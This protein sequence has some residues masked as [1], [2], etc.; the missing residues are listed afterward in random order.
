MI[1]GDNRAAVV[2]NIAQ[3]V[4]RGDLNTKVELNDPTLSPTERKRV[5]SRFFRQQATMRGRMQ[6]QVARSM[7]KAFATSLNPRPKIIG[8]Q[9]LA[10]VAGVGGVIVTAHHFNPRDSLLV[11]QL[12][13]QQGPRRFTGIQDTNLAMNGLLGFLMNHLDVLPLAPGIDYLGKTF[14]RL[15]NN[16]LAAGNWLLIYPE[17]EMWFNYRKPRPPKRGAYHYAAKNQVPILPSR[18]GPSGR[19]PTRTSLRP[20]TSSTC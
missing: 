3:A 15:V 16:T 5:L 13:D 20:A 8:R 1:I 10:Q 6:N 12:A 2:E 4:A 19:R 9:N 7:M 14:P 17:E 11:R 18:W